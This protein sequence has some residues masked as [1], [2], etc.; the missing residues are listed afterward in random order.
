MAL[1]IETKVQVIKERLGSVPVKELKVVVLVVK[2][3]TKR[4]WTID[5]V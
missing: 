1:N 2:R 5:F 4:Q 3:K